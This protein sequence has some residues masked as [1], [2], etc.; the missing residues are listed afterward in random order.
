MIKLFKLLIEGR[1]ED[2][3]KKYKTLPDDV[4]D[5]IIKSDPSGNNKYLDWMGRIIVTDKDAKLNDLIKD[6]DQFHKYQSSGLGDINKFKTLKD[7]QTALTTRNKSKGEQ[8]REGGK[9]LIDND[10]FLVVVPTTHDSCRYYGNNT[11]WCIVGN[12]DWWNKYFHENSIII[13]HNLK[14]N[15]KYAVVGTSD[16]YYDVYDEQD[17]SHRYNDYISDPEADDYWPEY[18]QDVIDDYMSSDDPESRKSN[19]YDI[20]VTSYIDDNG[21]DSFWENYL[22]KLH[23]EYD[24]IDD[25][26]LGTF[27]KIAHNRGISDEELESSAIIYMLEQLNLG[28]DKDHMD[29]VMRTSYVESVMLDVG[30]LIDPNDK[31]H[32]F[33][34]YAAADYIHLIKGIDSYLEIIKNSISE[35]LFNQLYYNGDLDDEL[36]DGIARYNIMLNS[37][38]Q[39]TLPGIESKKIAAQINDI[40]DV[41]YILNRTGHEDTAYKIQSD[42]GLKESIE[43]PPKTIVL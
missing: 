28:M 24:I 7:L 1:Q 3:K 38:Q 19:Y 10:D 40:N 34:E 8:T 21:S 13:I 26:D 22:D 4:K 35:S 2:F 30:R 5:I 9:I 36:Y 20:I 31:K 23:D 6:V 17:N 37:K 25:I 27:K 42:I 32:T 39:Q 16:G 12:V 33:L 15:E 14:I 11:R 29:D 43:R 18:V 41:I